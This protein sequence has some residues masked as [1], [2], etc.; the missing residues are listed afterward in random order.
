[1]IFSAEN[2]S[3]IHLNYGYNPLFEFPLPSQPNTRRNRTKTQ[4]DHENSIDSTCRDQDSNFERMA[5]LK[6]SSPKFIYLLIL[7]T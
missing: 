5:K 3:M 6:T 7:H 1:M 2:S 4:R